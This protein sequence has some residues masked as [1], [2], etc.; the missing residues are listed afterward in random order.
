MVRLVPILST[1]IAVAALSLTACPRTTQPAGDVPVRIL[2]S[3]DTAGWIVPCGCTTNQSGGL[4]RRGTYVAQARTTS[5]VLYLDAGGAPAGTSSYDRAKFEAILLGERTMGL[6]AHNLGASEAALGSSYLREVQTRL[7]FPF[8]SCNV[9]DA[10]GVLLT[11]AARVIE[12]AQ[13]RIA[14]LGV[15]SESYVSGSLRVDEPRQ[16]VLQTLASLTPPPDARI[17]LAYLP[18]DELQEFARSLPEVDLMI[19]GPTG[20]SIL[21]T[22]IGPTLLTSATNKG[23]YLVDLTAPR[24]LHGPW[25]G[26]VVEMNDALVDNAEQLANLQAFRLLLRQK[27]FAA[28]DTSFAPDLQYPA[29][30]RVAGTAR[31]RECHED[32]CRLWDDSG[33]A[34]A[35]QTLADTG[36]EVDAYCQSC[37]TTNFGLPGG[38]LSAGRSKDRQNVGCESCHGA[39]TAHCDDPDVRT[40]CYQQAANQCPTCHDHENSPQFVYNEYWPKIVHG[41][42]E[43]AAQDTQRASE[44]ARSP[45]D[46]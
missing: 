1:L 10:D 27:D 18:T 44:P 36:A 2:V 17:V 35:W 39:S 9:R 38:F 34:Q 42:D 14:I 3:G 12:T 21:P 31:C 6:V 7:T 5:D 26:N 22:Q 32:D 13:G 40:P 20:Q 30:Y 4:P 41:A 25:S 33:H 19:G 8:V 43:P 37:H 16:A 29:D 24:A 28:S 15:L 46:P 11:E 45:G 23:K